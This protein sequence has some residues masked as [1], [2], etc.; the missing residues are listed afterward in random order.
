MFDCRTQTTAR[1]SGIYALW[2]NRC[3]VTSRNGLDGGR[4]VL[5]RSLAGSL[6][7]AFHHHAPL[8]PPSYNRAQ[9]R[10]IRHAYRGSIPHSVCCYFG[11]LSAHLPLECTRH[12]SWLCSHGY[13]CTS[14]QTL[15]HFHAPQLHGCRRYSSLNSPS[16]P[17]GCFFRFI[18][19]LCCD[20]R[21]S[22]VSLTEEH[23]QPSAKK[24]KLHIIK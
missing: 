18:V 12:S 8:S 4:R 5:S 7:S 13:R 3:C 14:L 1:P 6:A 16:S 2:P 24:C 15:P 23:Y 11:I 17:K 22:R 20:F 10:S 21:A 9:A 19:L